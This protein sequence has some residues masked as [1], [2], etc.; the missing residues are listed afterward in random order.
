MQVGNYDLGT[1]KF[2]Y[3]GT[4]PWGS[5]GVDYACSQKS[6]LCAGYASEASNGVQTVCVWFLPI[7]SASDCDLMMQYDSSLALDSWTPGDLSWPCSRVGAVEPKGA[8]MQFAGP[9]TA[10]PQ[11]Y[12]VRYSMLCPWVCN[13][14][15]ECCSNNG[16]QLCEYNN[17]YNLSW[18]ATRTA[19]RGSATSTR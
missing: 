8:H 12:Q 2:T 15:N 18:A 19:A 17:D 1:C 13:G 14:P 7:A 6:V 5:A 10:W 16:V 11:S 3:T 9:T 4:G